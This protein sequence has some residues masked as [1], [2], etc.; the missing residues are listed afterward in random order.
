MNVLNSTSIIVNT[1]VVIVEAFIGLLNVA[2]IILSNGTHISK[3]SG[4]V[5]I[6]VGGIVT[7]DE[8]V[9]KLH[10]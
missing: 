4:S 3:S 8:P 1:A 2:V 6:I 5:E 10:T 9:V 7:G